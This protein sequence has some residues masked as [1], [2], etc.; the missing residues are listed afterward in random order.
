M[1]LNN[2]PWRVS[3]KASRKAPPTGGGTGM[4]THRRSS[5]RRGCECV[6]IAAFFLLL[7]VSLA[8]CAQS[9]GGHAN[10]TH[11]PTLSA[12]LGAV[13]AAPTCAGSQLG[14]QNKLLDESMN[15]GVEAFVI[16]NRGSVTCRIG[17]VPS[18]TITTTTGTPLTTPQQTAA[19][20]GSPVTL[21]PGA[22]A[23]FLL[24]GGGRACPYTPTS[25]VPSEYL[26]AE[27]SISIP[28]VSGVLSVPWSTS[29]SCSSQRWEVYPIAS[30]VPTLAP[31]FTSGGSPP[32]RSSPPPT[33]PTGTSGS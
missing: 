1:T 16:T 22:K 27:L 5:R 3:I 6:R 20:Q 2:A 31:G 8:A 24:A 12:A 21:A 10:A 29:G 19:A 26:H 4:T 30:G 17:G 15:Q 13:P 23:S 9:G 33:K 18:L 11:R 14:L 28:G 32:D 25:S 7:P